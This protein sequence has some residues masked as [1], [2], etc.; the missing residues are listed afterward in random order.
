MI[1]IL[2]TALIIALV[3]HG[4]LIVTGKNMIFEFVR[5]WLDKKFI[6]VVAERLPNDEIVYENNVSK[7]YYTILYCP[8]CMPSLWG[9]AVIITFVVAGLIPLNWHLVYV[10]PITLLCA[11]TISTILSEFYE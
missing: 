3:V 6:K 10:Y 11:V 7:C 5:N 8:R 2:K 9:T 4:A 1:T